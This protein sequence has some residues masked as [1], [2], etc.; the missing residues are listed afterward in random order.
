MFVRELQC[1]FFHIPKTAGTSVECWLG[2][3]RP[4]SSALDCEK[5]LGFDAAEDCFLNH[6]L[7]EKVLKRIGEEAFEACFRFS[8]VRN[9]FARA[10]SVYHYMY[11]QN[12]QRFGSFVDYIRALPALLQETGPLTRRLEPHIPQVRYTR[13]EGVDCCH[14]IV[15]FEQ[16]PGS[17]QPVARRLGI[18]RPLPFENAYRH[19]TR[20]CRP[21]SGFYTPDTAR[22]LV[23]LYAEDF[24]TFGYSTDP[25]AANE[26]RA[27]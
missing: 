1:I 6:V 23:D 26:S 22:M 21:V 5:L 8:V 4:I 17:L 25:E 20:G 13:L 14:E 9:P 15:R 18:S 27:Q 19:P 24:D 10:V 12:E 7:P 11:E 16:L 3:S 2:R